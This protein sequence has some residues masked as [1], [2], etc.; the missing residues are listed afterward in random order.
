[1]EGYDERPGA[2]G[3]SETAASG[4]DDDVTIAIAIAEIIDAQIVDEADDED[5]RAA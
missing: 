4:D 3:G 1:V 2:L 5:V